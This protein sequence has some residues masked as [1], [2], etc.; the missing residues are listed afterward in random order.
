MGQAPA[1][2]AWQSELDLVSTI[3][4]LV[5]D[6]IRGLHQGEDRLVM[7]M[8]RQHLPAGTAPSLEEYLPGPTC[9]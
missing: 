9:R 7:L 1:A 4:D 2:A 3:T 5:P 8:G 6:Q